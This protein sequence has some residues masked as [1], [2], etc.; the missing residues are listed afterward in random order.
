MFEVQ[1]VY[2]TLTS[3]KL[4]FEQKVAALAKH[5]ENGLDLLNIPPRTHHFFQTGAINDL[6]EGHAPYRPRYTMPDYARFV[7]QGSAFLQL[8]PPQDLDELL[9]SLL[10]LYRH[11]PS[12]TGFPVFLGDLDQLMEPFLV[13]HSDEAVRKKLR[14]FLNYLDRTITDSF[15]HANLGPTE[16]RATH[17]ILDVMAELQNAVPNFT[18][19]YDPAVTPNGLMEKAIAYSLRCANPAVCNDVANRDSFHCD[20]GISSCYNILPLGGGAYTLS[21]ITLTKLAEEAESIEHFLKVLLPECLN[22]LGDYMNER[23]GFLVEKSSFFESSFLIAEGLLHADRF[24]GMFGVTGLAESVNTLLR[25]QGLRF[26]RDKEADELGIQIMET[27]QSHVAT[28]TAVHSPLYNNRFVLHAQVG[29]DSD[30]GITSGVRIPVGQEPENFFEHLRHSSRF[31]HYFP[32]GVGDIFP[33]APTVGNNPAALLDVVRG[34]FSE[35]I[36]YM[37]FYAADSDLVRITGFLVKRSEMNKFRVEMPV[38]QNTTHLGMLNY[39]VNHL[40]RRKVRMV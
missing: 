37:S 33:I 11:V 1:A 23:I 35:G 30:V 18:I 29:L 15:C 9:F 26:G 7:A 32:A 27:I 3:H 34:A 31:H 20:Y 24:V 10:T 25:A 13:E 19:K 40:D 16:T 38:L 39:D 5:A 8:P 12:I 14:L 4:T 17:L 22:C 36:H 28:L 6:F 2:G 21:R